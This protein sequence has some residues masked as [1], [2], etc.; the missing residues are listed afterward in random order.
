M[1]LIFI[2]TWT[3]L[4]GYL[5][6]L[7]K[8]QRGSNTSAY[9]QIWIAFF[10]SGI[11]H[12]QSM[13]LLPFPAEITLS[14]RSTGIMAF[15]VWQALAITL[16]DIAQWMWKKTISPTGKKSQM[17]TVIGYIWVIMSFWISLPWAADV[18]MR[19]R[20]TEKSFLGFTVMRGLVQKLPIS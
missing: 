13:L 2:Q 18:M 8:I 16:E 12:A 19:V 17:T 5:V 15:F 4:T 14:E 20:L 10:A 7:F 11:M 9:A 3:E 1:V 6:D